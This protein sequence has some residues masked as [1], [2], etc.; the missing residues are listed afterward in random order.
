MCVLLLA[1]DVCQHLLL[2]GLARCV[3]GWFSEVNVFEGLIPA[4][5]GRIVTSILIGGGSQIV[6]AVVDKARDPLAGAFEV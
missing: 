2:A 4:L 6:H 3:L 5:T 1:F